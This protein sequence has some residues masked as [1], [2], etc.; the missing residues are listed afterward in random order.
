MIPLFCDLFSRYAEKES[1]RPWLLSNGQVAGYVTEYDVGTRFAYVTIK[2]AGHMV[3]T[4]RPKEAQ[5][6]IQRFLNGSAF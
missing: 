5:V 4:F 1:F 3:P 6:M 2:G